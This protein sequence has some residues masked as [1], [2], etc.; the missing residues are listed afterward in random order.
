VRVQLQAT[1]V[2]QAV[3]LCVSDDGVGLP[4][5]FEARREAALGLQLVDDLAGQ[6]SGA[7][8]I[9]PGRAAVFVVSFTPLGS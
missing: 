8:T 1:G 5:D 2:G 7:L 6:L 4:E 3:R 9:G